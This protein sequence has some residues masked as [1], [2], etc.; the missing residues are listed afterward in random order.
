MII[1]GCGASVQRRRLEAHWESC[2]M[3]LQKCHICGERMKSQR[4]IIII[5]IIILITI[6]III[7]I[8]TS[9][10]T[11][12]II[13]ISHIIHVMMMMMILLL[14]LII[15]ISITRM[16]EHA[17]EAAELHVRILEDRLRHNTSSNNN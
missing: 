7:I 15:I 2:E 5:F 14:L 12:I 11:I 8:T 9:A 1:E 13:I 4:I 17:R 3:N 6:V 10:R 16:A